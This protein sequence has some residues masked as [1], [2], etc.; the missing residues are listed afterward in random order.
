[1]CFCTVS[2]AHVHSGDL[3]AVASCLL[4]AAYLSYQLLGWTLRHCCLLEDVHPAQAAASPAGAPL[5]RGVSVRSYG[6]VDDSDL[7]L[8]RLAFADVDARK[9]GQSAWTPPHA[10]HRDRGF[11][12]G[13]RAAVGGCAAAKSLALEQSFV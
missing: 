2:S 6:V 7:E 5:R 1:M 8:E 4:L 12:N 11:A 13:K 3:A 9:A 10:E